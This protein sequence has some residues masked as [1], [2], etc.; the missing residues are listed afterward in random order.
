MEIATYSH[1][2]PSHP[3]PT[4][5]NHRLHYT[6]SS[7]PQ[8][9]NPTPPLAAIT[10]S[11]PSSS[12]LSSPLSLSVSLTHTLAIPHIHHHLNTRAT[13]PSRT[14]PRNIE[15]DETSHK[16]QKLNTKSPWWY[17]TS[18]NAAVNLNRLPSKKSPPGHSTRLRR[19]GRA[20]NARNHPSHP[21]P[22]CMQTTVWAFVCPP[23]RTDDDAAP[24]HR[25][26]SV[27][28]TERKSDRASVESHAERRRRRR[29]PRGGRARAG[30][31]TDE[32]DPTIGPHI[33]CWYFSSAFLL[34]GG[35]FFGRGFETSYPA[36][37]GIMELGHVTVIRYDVFMEVV[38]YVV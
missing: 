28:D 5:L 2:A 33:P 12:S 16:I 38:F 13:C 20:E 22:P 27:S 18:A 26:P 23:S 32:W 11:P 30:A 4:Q 3:N 6:R 21:H 9:P 35:L 31:A 17:P 19:R 24:Q 1:L 25:T 37:T 7:A 10:H 34:S 8:P 14:P 36:R 29:L 15:N